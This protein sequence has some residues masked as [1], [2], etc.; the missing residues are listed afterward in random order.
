MKNL[1]DAVSNKV[2]AEAKAEAKKKVEAKIE[3]ETNTGA[4]VEAEA[5]AEAEAAV[6]K[7]GIGVVAM[8]AILN[9]A[10]NE[11]TLALIHKEFP[12]GKTTKASINWYRNKLRKDEAVCTGGLWKGKAVPNAREMNK[13]AKAAAEGKSAEEAKASDNKPKPEEADPTA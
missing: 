11:E 4:E 2:R 12:E 8:E 5:E 7:R 6:P 13:I 1:S 9:G 10:S 3:A